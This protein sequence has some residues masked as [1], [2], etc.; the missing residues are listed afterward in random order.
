M[1]FKRKEY[2]SWN[3]YYKRVRMIDEFLFQQRVRRYNIEVL[4]RGKASFY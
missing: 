2:L 4:T 1:W 3:E